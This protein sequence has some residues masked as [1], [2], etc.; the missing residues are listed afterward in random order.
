[1][2][3]TG[4]GGLSLT[5]D[6]TYANNT[7]AGTASASYSYAGDANHGV[8]SD[9]KTFTIA[10]AAS[11]TTVTFEA[12]PY[13]YRG[14]PFTATVAVTG[15]GGLSL[16][17]SPSYG[18]SDCL[19]VTVLNGCTASYSYAGDANH[20]GS[21]DSKSITLT[22]A[23]ATIGLSGLGT[24]VYDGANHVSTATTSPAGL[25]VVTIT[26]NGG[27]TAPMAVGTYNVVATLTNQNY[28]AP[29]ATGTITI[30][31]W[32]TQ[33]FY[34]PVDMLPIVNGIKGGSTVPLK[35]N[36]FAGSTE[37]KTTA[38]VTAVQ[39]YAISCSASNPVDDIPTDALATGGTGLRYDTTGGQFIFNW[40]S[41]KGANQ[42]F[43]VVVTTADGG[44]ALRARF[45]TK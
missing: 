2:T 11:V 6:P 41:P 21:S 35:F 14:T 10:K 24:F 43:D 31:P 32:T 5:P 9:S 12:G 20:L 23:P 44:T 36:V 37:Q 30:S 27:S 45:K 29:N 1:V 33:G 3:V 17:P 18:A 7:N 13:V 8:S 40:Q 38:A 28:S 22:Q 16:A 34:Q 42:C 25:T 19:N 15:V 39:Q 26:Y 4:A